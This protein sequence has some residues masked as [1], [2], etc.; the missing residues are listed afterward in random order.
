MYFHGG[1]KI[2]SL[3]CYNNKVVV[4]NYLQ[5]H[6]I[7]WYHITLS[8][9]GINRTEETKSQHVFWPKMRDQITTYVQPCPNYQRNKG[10]VKKY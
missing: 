1:G 9:P 10:K 2:R 5:Q 3:I 8:H 7:D 4:P 6:A